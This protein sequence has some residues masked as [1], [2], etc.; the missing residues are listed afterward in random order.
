MA[1]TDFYTRDRP[2][3]PELPEDRPRGRSES[4]VPE[5]HRI[6]T[7]TLLLIAFVVLVLVG[8]LLFP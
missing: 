4:Y 5:H 3:N 6:R 8:I 2:D 1:D 7:T